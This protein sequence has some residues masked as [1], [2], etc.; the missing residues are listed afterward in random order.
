MSLRDREGRIPL[1]SAP[2]KETLDDWPEVASASPRLLILLA[3]V[4]GLCAGYLDLGFLLLTR[5]WWH[6]EGYL[7]T[8]RDFAW[9]VP[10]GHA[11]LSGAAGLGLAAASAVRRNVVSL[12]TG[13]WVLAAFALWCTLLRLPLFGWAS[14][15]LAAGLGRLVGEAVA[16]RDIES[17]RLYRALAALGGVL[18]VLAFVTSGRQALGESFT[19]A[20]LPPASR[21]ARN[22]VLVV[23]DTVRAYNTGLGSYTRNT[24][25]K[26]VEWAGSGVTYERAIAP[27][28]WT[29][30]SHA[31][32]FTGQWPLA[33]NAQWKLTLDSRD[34]TLAEFLASNGYQTAGFAANTNCCSYESGLSRGFAHYEDYELAPQSLFTRTV[35]GKWLLQEVARQTDFYW[36]K[37][38]GLESRGAGALTDALLAWLSRR[39]TDRPFFAFLNYFDAH[40]PY[41]PPPSYEGRFGIR[42]QNNREYE[43]LFNF[44]GMAKDPQQ[45]RPIVMARDCYDDCVAFLD[46][47]L[48]RLLA[49]LKRQGI[50]ENT[51]VIITS[52]HG[53]AF[54]EHGTIG[55]S[56]SVYLDEIFVPLVILAPGAPA[57]RAVKEPAS[58]RD[59]PATVVDLAGIATA[60]PFSG[61]SL[62]M[63]WSNAGAQATGLAKSS[64][65]FAEQVDRAAAHAPAQNGLERSEFKMSLVAS[66]FHYIRDDKG[67]EKLFDLRTDRFEQ[68]DLARF[69][70][71]HAF[72]KMLLQ[73]LNQ[74][75]G[76]VEV[77]RAYLERFRQQ[78]KSVVEDTEPARLGAR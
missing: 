29:Y 63:S 62:A 16:A 24:T 11:L 23:W 50:L 40:E 67:T 37:W 70:G 32:F 5:L 58:L 38:I 18:V 56:Y 61:R 57:G 31:C 7:R 3:I 74:N 20:N 45:R 60:S 30:P 1:R 33:L 75:K 48:G 52:D 65:A 76:S 14:L 21:S 19:V 64:P 26:L 71:V 36:R 43:Q 46:Q 49:N 2:P 72:R 44:V 66:G 28:P 39:R 54:G 22:V 13:T 15:I 27:A 9:T 10:L 4:F 6:P 53:E 78:L 17:R 47:E 69:E 8:A 51:V 34:P 55:H 73:V 12:R 42:P 25:P 41:I 59:L 68:R 77:E 35:P